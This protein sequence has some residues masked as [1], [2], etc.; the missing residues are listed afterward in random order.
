MLEIT[1]PPELPVSQRREEIAAAIRDHQVVIVAGET[2]S[3]KTTQLPK[4]CLELGRES[5]GHTQP[6]RIAA[7]TIAERVAEELDTEVGDLVGY[8]VRFT[9]ESSK[10]TKVKLMTDGILLAELRG[11]RNLSRYDTIIIDEAHERSLN[12][13][14]LLGYL[15]RLL[16]KRPDLK[17]IITSAT[18]DPESFSK[19]FSDAPIIEV[20]GRTYPVDVRYRPLLADAEDPD[21]PGQDRDVFEGIVAA[22]DELEGEAPGDVLVFLP[23]E[24]EIRDAE[25]AIRGSLTGRR[26][27]AT[28]VLPLYGRLSAR[29][30]HRV[31]EKGRAPG[32]RR[33][34]VL[35]TNVAETSLTVPGIAYVI[36]TGE[37]RI[38]RYSTRAK[39]QRLPIEPISQASANQRSGRSGRTRDGIAIR[40]YGEDDFNSRPEFTDP[41]ILRTNL[42]SV[43]LQMLELG[44]GAIEDFPFLTPPDSRGV[45]DG[46]DLLRELGAI[47][48]GTRASRAVPKL[49]R[50]GR[51]LAR[52]PIDPRYGRMVLASKELDVAREILIIVSGLTIQ[53]IRE[54]PLEHRQQADQLHARFRDPTSDFF[55][56]LNLW[57][58]LEAQSHALGSSAFRRLC[59]KEFLNFVRFREWQDLFRQLREATRGLGLRIQ[60][61]KHETAPGAEI[62]PNAEPGANADAVHKAMLTGLLS[63]IGVYDQ[64]KRDYKGA[65]NTRFRIFPGS[66]LAKSNPDAVMAAELVET[67]ALFARTVAKIDPAWAEEFAGDLVKRQHAEP[68]WERKQGQAVALETV[69]LYGVPLVKGRRVGFAK[70]D[71]V[72]SRDLFI[73]HALVEGDWTGHY[74]FERKNR[75]LRREL[76]ELEERT[77]QRGLIEDDEVLM[78]FFSERI[79]DDVVSQATFDKWWREA[80]KTQPDLLTLTRADL[81]GEDVDEA[82]DAQFPRV[83]KQGEQQL[84]LRYKFDP[85]SADD[86]VTATIPLPLLAMLQPDGFDWLVPGLRAELV[87]ALLRSLPKVIRRN[88]VAA[89][90]WAAKLLEESANERSLSAGGARVSKGAD[91]S[92]RTLSSRDSD[93]SKRTIATARPDLAEPVDGTLTEV[94]RVHMQRAAGIRFDV[95]E[96]DLAK[97]PSH[98]LMRFRVVDDSGRELGAGS[99]LIALQQRLKRASE[100]ALIHATTA[101]AARSPRHTAEGG[102]RVGADGTVSRSGTRESDTGRSPRAGEAGVSRGAAEANFDQREITAWP[103]D[104]I[105]ESFEIRRKHGVIRAWPTLQLRKPATPASSPIDLVL[106]TTAD[107]QQREHQRA[108]AALLARSVPTPASYVQSHLTSHE[109]LSLASSPYQS[110]DALLADV[111]IALANAAMPEEPV[112]TRAQ[113]EALR[114]AF[115]ATLVDAMF[116]AVKLVAEILKAHR[117]AL[118]AIKNVNALAYLGSL[119]DAKA[120]L[121]GLIFDGFVSRT[122]MDQ[123]RHLPRYLRAV[124]YRLERLQSGA[125]TERSGMLEIEKATE[126]YKAAGGEIPTGPN[127]PAGFVQVRWMLEEFRVSLFAQQLGTAQTVSLKRIRA[128]LSA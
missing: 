118:A 77:R 44:L 16:P 53:D 64:V 71:P 55:T 20:S 1:Y 37:A 104:E 56:L 72:W 4:I 78:E 21:A 121:E 54:R 125:A 91:A 25:D 28:E 57:N 109:K 43:L 90:D 110:T 36:D 7:R 29:D 3:G 50:I 120:Q 79:P 80:Q 101:D 60:R 112:S 66:G 11:D 119:T 27:A 17:V 116:A 30:Q 76:E 2:G 52:L 22:L 61:P 105:P 124:T 18:I 35:A 113:F 102:L 42:A 115:N 32:V 86:G 40:L 81:L 46:V 100:A 23:G 126:L 26:R 73:R 68:H 31:F 123:L 15:K 106:A 75:Q 39:V 74:P 34:V 13:D 9:D 117:E 47:R 128:A 62:A 127:A 41:E 84:K 67:S 94:L 12:V 99:D 8:Q 107:D 5:I 96:F 69:T 65:R 63:H 10:A 98:L 38:S 89:A 45:K 58:Y 6:R 103:V 19:H 33:R 59:K 51:D 93:V 95:E 122:G 49:T 87:T 111:L 14:F 83:W 24:R 88:F 48:G 108:V 70:I 114:D 82:D 85:N 92:N 97:I